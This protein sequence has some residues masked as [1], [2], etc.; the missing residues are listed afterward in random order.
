MAQWLRVLA[1]LPEVRFPAPKRQLTTLEFQSSSRES[2]AFCGLFRHSMYVMY[3][4]TSKQNTH[5]CEINKIFKNNKINLQ[6][7]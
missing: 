4:H 1:T 3:I 7:L 5:T 6:T 2:N